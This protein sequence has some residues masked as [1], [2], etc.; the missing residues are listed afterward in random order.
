MSQCIIYPNVGGG[1]SVLYQADPAFSLLQLA[2]KDVPADTEYAIINIAALPCRR[3]FREAWR[4]VNQTVVIDMEAAK[5]IHR[6]RWRAAREPLLEALDVAFMKALEINDTV[7]LAEIA[8]QKQALRDVT[9]T[10][11]SGVNTPEEL[12]AVWPAILNGE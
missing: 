12:A 5:D 9:E 10:D 11:L 4:Y 2:A 1:V 3:C 6:D 8:A 7:T